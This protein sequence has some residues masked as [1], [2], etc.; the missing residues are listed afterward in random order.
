[1]MKFERPL[2][3]PYYSGLAAHAGFQIVE[4]KEQGAGKSFLM[5]LRKP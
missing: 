2:D 1:M 3:V 5:R 4:V